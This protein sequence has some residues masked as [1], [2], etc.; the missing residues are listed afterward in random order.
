MVVLPEKHQAINLVQD[1]LQHQMSSVPCFI[2]ICSRNQLHYGPLTA[3]VKEVFWK[4]CTLE[5]T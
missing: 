2:L 1:A 5:G 4:V 3:E